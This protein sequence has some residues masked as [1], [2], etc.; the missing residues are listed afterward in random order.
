MQLNHNSFFFLETSRNYFFLL[1]SALVCY[2]TSRNAFKE[3]FTLFQKFQ[4]QCQ[5]GVFYFSSV[6]F[7]SV[8]LKLMDINSSKRVMKH[9]ICQRRSLPGMLALTAARRTPNSSAEKNRS[10][11]LGSILQ[12]ISP[13]NGS[14]KELR[15]VIA[16]SSSG[17]NALIAR[18]R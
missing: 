3:R 12:L 15:G 2:S 1:K 16:P 5:K 18:H 13:V 8:Y 4:P 14:R 11:R 6:H 7:V 9:P 10:V 17:W